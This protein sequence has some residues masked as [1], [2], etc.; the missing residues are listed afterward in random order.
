MVYVHQDDDCLAVASDPHYTSSGKVESDDYEPV[1]KQIG[2]ARG[3]TMEWH[4]MLTGFVN[5]FHVCNGLRKASALTG[6]RQA[7]QVARRVADRICRGGLSPSGLFWAAFVPGNVVSQNGSFPNP[8]S[9]TDE[10][11]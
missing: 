1:I 5:G 8:I 2:N 6:G 3:I 10:D 4:E 7:G 9:R 11:G